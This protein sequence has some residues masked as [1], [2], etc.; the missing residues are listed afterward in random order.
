MINWLYYSDRLISVEIAEEYQLR[1][2]RIASSIEPIEIFMK[3]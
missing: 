3:Q 2:I 1:G